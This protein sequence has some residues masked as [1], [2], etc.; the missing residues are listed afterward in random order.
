MGV[1][2]AACCIGLL[3]VSALI[4]QK[5]V[6]KNTEKSALYFSAKELFEIMIKNQDAVKRDNYADCIS[7]GI[8][9]HLGN[10]E[11]IEGSNRKNPFIRILEGRYTR[12]EGENVDEGLRRTIREGAP[13]N[14]TY[15]RYWHGGAAVIRIL[16]PLMD[17]SAMR[18]LFFVIGMLLNLVWITYL[19]FRR[20]YIMAISYLMGI[21]FGK[22]LFGYACF[23][24]AFV[25]FLIPI[26]SALIYTSV[27]RSQEG[28][29]SI[30]AEG[31]FLTAGILTCFFDFLTAETA[32]FT[33]PAFIAF[34]CM[35]SKK[36]KP[37]IIRTE[38]DKKNKSPWLFLFRIAAF[39]FFGYAGMFG[40]KWGLNAL[41]LGRE[42]AMRA[43]SSVAERT[44]GEVNETLNAFS[45]AVGFAK[46][47]EGIFVHN[48]SCLCGIPNNTSQSA[49]IL[50]LLGTPAILYII[51]FFFRK[52]ELLNSLQNEKGKK[53]FSLFPIFLVIA[54]IPILRFVILSNHSYLHYFFTYRALMVDVMILV[55]IFIRTT[56]L[57]DLL[58]YH[59]I[60]PARS[61]SR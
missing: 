51:W 42:E 22:I 19:V 40:L 54:F 16:L 38:N 52:K 25:C 20:E 37:F 44:V 32:V 39:W 12:D 55:Y 4:P 17:I 21:I 50:I 30:P 59:P 56:I 49:T 2:A 57:S 31:L 3:L 14:K 61:E 43:F 8:A 36:T 10:S 35:D 26:F 41:F 18:V 60:Q 7:T 11:P 13:A 6:T 1:L 5:A 46:R 27:R 48:F 9:Y 45:P 24:Y 58:T 53:E 47:L 33:I 23:E 28:K 34:V 29:K 15:S